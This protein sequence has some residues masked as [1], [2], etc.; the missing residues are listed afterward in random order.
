M[1]LTAKQHDEYEARLKKRGEKRPTDRLRTER[2]HL[3]SS[4]PLERRVEEATRT[5]GKAGRKT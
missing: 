3:A 1:S 2:S 4:D 5:K